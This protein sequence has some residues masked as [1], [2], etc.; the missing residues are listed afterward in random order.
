MQYLKATLNR[1]TL[2]YFLSSSNFRLA[3]VTHLDVWRTPGL[4]SCCC[5][6]DPRD[7]GRLQRGPWAQLGGRVE[8]TG[9]SLHPTPDWEQNPFKQQ[10]SSF[11]SLKAT[12]LICLWMKCKCQPSWR[13][14][15]RVKNWFCLSWILL[16]C[17]N[18]PLPLPPVWKTFIR[19]TTLL[20]LLHLWDKISYNY[21]RKKGK[22]IKWLWCSALPSR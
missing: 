13:N 9:A 5:C 3:G 20:P 12:I 1:S 19:S 10:G 8:V 14:S 22:T 15:H 17:G 7:P 21:S 2:E 11:V 16:K 18:L 6:M 4:R